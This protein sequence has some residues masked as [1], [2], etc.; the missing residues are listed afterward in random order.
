MK[1]F[2]GAGIVARG[3]DVLT[4]QVFWGDQIARM[5]D[6][7]P[8][9]PDA[10]RVLDLGAGPGISAFALA[11]RLGENERITGLD[12]SE[13]MVAIAR[14][15]HQKR[16]PHLRRIEFV[17]GDAA[18]MPFADASFDVAFG[19]SFL[20]LTT[21][22]RAVLREVRRVLVPGGR[23]VLMDPDAAGSIWRA[24]RVAPGHARRALARPISTVRF[25]AS[26]FVWRVV[27]SRRNALTADELGLLLREEGFTDVRCEPTLG[28]LGTHAVGT[29]DESP[30]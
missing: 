17:Q 11:R 19:H 20:Y 8:D 5:A 22:R 10:P 29:R 9:L 27:V 4:N 26:M 25:A 14:R 3:Y 2:W 7:V 6:L 30:A 24:G 23:L 16:Y 1:R 21:D 18:A 12:F 13:K 15:R 28:G